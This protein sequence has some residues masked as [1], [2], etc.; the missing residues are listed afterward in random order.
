[1]DHLKSS[2]SRRMINSANIDRILNPCIGMQFKKAQ[3]LKQ[4]VWI[5]IRSILMFLISRNPLSE[6]QKELLLPGIPNPITIAIYYKR[7]SNLFILFPSVK[8]S[9][10]NK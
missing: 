2:F 8:G 7:I 9:F 10:N 4:V 6:C 1:M 5:G 3:Q